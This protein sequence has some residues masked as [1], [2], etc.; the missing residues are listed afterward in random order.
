[1]LSNNKDTVASAVVKKKTK[2]TGM[3]DRCQ[4]LFTGKYIEYGTPRSLFDELNE[5]LHFV[6]DPCT[7]SDNPL[8]TRHFFTKQDD[9]LTQSWGFRGSVFVNPPYGK[10]IIEWVK[11]AF[12]ESVKRNINVVM[13]LP[14]RTDTRFFHDYI[15]NKPNVEVR[16][17][18]GRLKFITSV[19]DVPNTAPYPSMVVVFNKKSTEL[20]QLVN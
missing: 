10:N 5:E 4:A 3:M 17:I 19:Q 15:Y 11:K 18:R 14:A 9:G 16:F 12:D 2:I 8:Q 7:T 1:M 20:N 13:L 6:L